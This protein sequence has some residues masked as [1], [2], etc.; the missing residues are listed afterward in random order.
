MS[1]QGFLFLQL[2]G[3]HC[4][5]PAAETRGGQDP[6]HRLGE[7]LGAAC[8]VTVHM[9]QAILLYSFSLADF[10][11]EN[12]SLKWIVLLIEQQRTKPD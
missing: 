5:T 11:E 9:W 6:D 10:R 7:F 8:D 3:H 2:G 1:W 12:S 4:Q